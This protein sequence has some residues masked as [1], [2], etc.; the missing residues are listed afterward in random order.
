MLRWIDTLFPRRLL[1]QE[2]RRL[3]H[4]FVGRVLSSTGFAIVLPFLSLYLHGTRGVPMTAVGALFL[5]ASL[6]GAIGQVIGGEWS[7]RSGRKVVLV[8]SQLL[9]AVAF[10]SLGFAVL[11]HA[12]FYVF[13]LATSLSAFGGRMYEP[14]S[15]AMVADMAG[16][17]R[18]AEYYGVLRIAGN[19]GWALGPAIGGFLAALSYSSLF[20]VGSGVMIGSAAIMAF[21]VEE[22]SPMHQP[23][24]LRPEPAIAEIPDIGQ[25]AAAPRF[26]L[27]ESVKALRDPNFL[28][29]LLISMML[30]VVMAQLI[31]TLSVYAVEWAGLSKVQLGTLYALNGLTVVFLQ[32]PAV[33]LTRTLRLTTSLALGAVLYGLGYGIMGWGRGMAFLLGATFIVSIGEIIA[34]PPS[35]QLV[36][37]FSGETTR[38]RYM[39]IFG[40]FN[41]IGWSLGPVV[42]GALLDSF[43]GR[44]IIVWSVIT[45]L[46]FLAAVGYLDLRRRLPRSL[47]RDF[48]TAPAKSAVA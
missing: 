5:I 44:P 14:P 2:D 21:G 23:R 15:G 22:T 20:L 12:P 24:R 9:R 32:F 17:D 37:N 43:H 25:A 1:F 16:L 30:F 38:G 39:G 6:G 8:A 31:V 29:Y 47:D 40:V 7:D 4:L 33:K 3:L 36:A 45:A 48:E 26:Q 11:K 41:S 28:R 10:A 46:A 19:L 35:L 34:T 42:G 13:V 18:Q 27:Q